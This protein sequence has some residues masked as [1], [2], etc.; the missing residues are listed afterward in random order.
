MKKGADLII[1]SAGIDSDEAIAY[2]P[3]ST[4][5]G[6]KNFWFMP[7]PLCHKNWLL[8][9]GFKDVEI[10]GTSKLDREEQRVTDFA[11]QRSLEEGLDPKNPK[12]TIEGYPRP[13]RMI[14]SAKR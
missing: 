4:Y 5:G 2:F 8:R 7:S 14:L 1:E 10:I 12:N 9:A 3:E 13:I 11:S 6:A